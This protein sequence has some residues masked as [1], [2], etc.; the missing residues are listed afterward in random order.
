[1]PSRGY[2]GRQ[3][4]YYDVIKTARMLQKIN[5]PSTNRIIFRY[6]LRLLYAAGRSNYDF[7]MLLGDHKVTWFKIHSML[8]KKIKRHR[9]SLEEQMTMVSLSPLT[10][11]YKDDVLP[12]QEG[13]S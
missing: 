12:L 3:L 6:E 13:P 4:Y 1:M 10:R 7:C 8:L 5:F 2:V 11:I 9:N